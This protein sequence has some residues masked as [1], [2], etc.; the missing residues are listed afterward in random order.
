MT[1]VPPSVSLR[2]L[3]RVAAGYILV[4]MLVAVYA[5]SEFQ[6]RSIAAAGVRLQTDEVLYFQLASAFLWAWCTPLLVAIA[7][8]LRF[9]R[10]KVRDALI[11]VVTVPAL[12]VLR[13]A[14]GGAAQSM[15]EEQ[16]IYV[17]FVELSVGIR[18]HQNIFRI[19][20]IFAVTWLV[21]AWREGAQR[22]SRM[23]ELEHAL[24]AARLDELRVRLQPDFLRSALMQIADRI[25]R[26]SPDSDDLLVLLGDLLRWTLQLGRQERVVLQDE[27]EFLDRYFEFH[28]KLSGSE[29]EATFEVDEE[30]LSSEVPIMLLQPLAN[31]AIDSA[32]RSGAHRVHLTI[33]AALRGERLVLEIE[34]DA[35]APQQSALEAIR[36]RLERYSPFAVVSQVMAHARPV[37][38]IEV[39]AATGGTA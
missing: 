6:R 4:W 35:A 28:R 9:T 11:L 39:P 34:N 5:T 18:L 19:L 29:V 22:E 10:H 31:D 25:E 20:V 32:L 14:V 27:L 30:L 2:R 8:R 24:A 17:P 15:V 12:S 16:R 23:V 37:T 7:E 21:V 33:R 3:A 36:T 38:R 13:A 26:G 1:R